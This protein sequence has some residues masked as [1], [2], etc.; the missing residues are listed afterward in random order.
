MVKSTTSISV[1]TFTGCPQGTSLYP[2]RMPAG[3]ISVPEN[4]S[5][6]CGVRTVSFSSS[7]MS[8]H[9]VHS[10]VSSVPQTSLTKTLS[11][12]RRVS[13][14]RDYL[15]PSVV[16]PL[17]PHMWPRVIVHRLCVTG[18]VWEGVGVDSVGTWRDVPL[19]TNDWDDTHVVAHVWHTHKCSW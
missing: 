15:F 11:R 16:G 18:T 19:Q 9:S 4:V 5:Y 6:R 14:S 3:H 13:F 10:D 8:V 12:K 7:C 2:S 17:V 1:V